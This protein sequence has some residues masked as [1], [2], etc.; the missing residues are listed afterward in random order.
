MRHFNPVFPIL[1]FSLIALV[2]AGCASESPSR[3]S[4]GLLRSACGPAGG[5]TID[6]VLTSTEIACSTPPADLPATRLSVNA[7]GEIDA[8]ESVDVERAFA[9]ERCS[10]GACGGITG[11][12]L[13][14]LRV[15]GDRA[16]LRWSLQLEDGTLDEGTAWVHVCGGSGGCL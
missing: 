4:Q 9:A 7:F 8:L 12:S 11:G 6:L 13:E 14:T 15:D 1:S 5:S 2:L 16:K 3:F 10:D